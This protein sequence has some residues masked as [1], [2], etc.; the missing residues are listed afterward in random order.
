MSAPP[1]DWEAQAE[2]ALARGRRCDRWIPSFLLD[3]PI[4]AL[5]F[6]W[7]TAVGIVWGSLWSTGRVEN[8]DG[9][10]VFRGMPSWAYGRGGVCVGRC[11]LTGNNASPSVL[12]HEAVHVQQWRRYGI[13]MPLLYAMAGRNALRNRFEIEAGLVKGGYVHPRYARQ[14][15]AQAG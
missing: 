6:A 2:R 14:P 4:S 1:A 13:L 11:Y 7:G 8:I 15:T 10:L 12:A 9:L 5:G 3:S